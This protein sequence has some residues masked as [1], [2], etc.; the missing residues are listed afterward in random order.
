MNILKTEEGIS[1]A[2][3]VFFCPVEVLLDRDR[4]PK[5]PFTVE[6]NESALIIKMFHRLSHKQKSKPQLACLTNVDATN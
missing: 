4:R 3:L 5:I 2:G 6:A 1:F